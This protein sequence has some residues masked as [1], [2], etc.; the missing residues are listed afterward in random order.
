[1]GQQA[2]RRSRS[3]ETPLF[4]LSRFPLL[5]NPGKLRSCSRK[6]HAA[7]ASSTGGGMHS[8]IAGATCFTSS[9][10]SGNL[11]QGAVP[12]CP[13]RFRS[14]G[15]LTLP[16][17]NRARMLF[18]LAPVD[19][20]N[21]T[22]PILVLLCVT[23]SMSPKLRRTAQPSWQRTGAEHITTAQ[24]S[25]SNRAVA[26]Q[27]PW[28]RTRLRMAT[29]QPVRPGR[30]VSTVAHPTRASPHRSFKA[31]AA[32]IGKHDSAIGCL[33]Q[34]LVCQL[35]LSA[36]SQCGRADDTRCNG[37]RQFPIVALEH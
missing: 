10:G 26:A 6:L 2:T 4:P 34:P 9:Q 24:L 36:Q 21:G 28:W 25:P 8:G 14:H 22:P 15:G 27:G 19:A 1:V 20:A 31:L 32:R 37:R 35:S 33:T 5:D 16:A 23:P 12:G 13:A 17:H 18:R 7:A 11:R 30:Q 29:H 3:R